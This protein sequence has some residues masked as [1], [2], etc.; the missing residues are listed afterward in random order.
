MLTDITLED[1][2]IKFA[3][4]RGEADRFSSYN[5][6]GFHIVVPEDKVDS[7]KAS[8]WNVKTLDRV[9]DD[10]PMELLSVTIN[11]NGWI[12]QLVNEKG[13]SKTM[14][15]EVCD[16]LYRKTK[17]QP[18]RASVVIR[19]YAWE[20]GDKSGVKAYLIQLDMSK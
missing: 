18:F 11:L 12:P 15:A 17:N 5:N 9:F 1:V 16:G 7:L 2:E 4:F 13:H 10:G 8:G 6:R 14:D 19:P 3:N 20:I